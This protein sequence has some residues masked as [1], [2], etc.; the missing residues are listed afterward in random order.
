MS[1]DCNPMADARWEMLSE[2]VYAGRRDKFKKPELKQKILEAWQEINLAEIQGS[3]SHW[4]KR[5]RFVIEQ[6]GG[7]IEHFNGEST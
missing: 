2:K 6:D 1:A 5:L 4:K 7:H 3:A